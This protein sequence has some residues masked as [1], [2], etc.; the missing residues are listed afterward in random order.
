MTTNTDLPGNHGP[1]LRTAVDAMSESTR[2]AFLA[3]LI[4]ATSA[5]YLAD[6]LTRAGTPISASTLRTYRRTLRPHLEPR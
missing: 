5:E 2:R 4:G 6:W 1:R 3:H